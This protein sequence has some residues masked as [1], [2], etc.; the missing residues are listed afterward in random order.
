AKLT[1][2]YP[3]TVAQVWPT[4]FGVVDASNPIS[5][6]T[7]STLDKAWNGKLRPDWTDSQVDPGG[8]TWPSV[9]C[10]ALIGGD[11][12]RGQTH[13]L[14][15]RNRVFPKGSSDRAFMPPFTVSDAGW[16]IFALSVVE[17]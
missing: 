2:W 14:W 6:R 4:L 3:D 13:A 11:T 17:K 5:R 1:V 15:V 7:F 10:A 16:L 12:K 8:F 9:A